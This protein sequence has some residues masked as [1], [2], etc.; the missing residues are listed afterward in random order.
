ME[1]SMPNQNPEQIARDKIDAML[2]AAGWSVQDHN[3]PDLN[4]SLGVALREYPTSTGPTDYLR[5]L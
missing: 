1:M 4:A 2:L 3:M 5:A